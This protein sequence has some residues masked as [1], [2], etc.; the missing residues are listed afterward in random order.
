MLKALLIELYNSWFT[1]KTVKLVFLASKGIQESYFL[2]FE[3]RW[4][5]WKLALGQNF[6]KIIS[7][8]SRSVAMFLRIQTKICWRF[9]FNICLRA[10][11]Y[12]VR[13]SKTKANKTTKQQI[14]SHL[15]RVDFSRFLVVSKAAMQELNCV[16]QWQV[17]FCGSVFAN[18]DRFILFEMNT[19]S[20]KLPLK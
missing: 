19:E 3:L 11:W 7:D 5:L 20:W 10:V 15:K 18:P 13:S 16:A 2:L 8:K 4:A 6:I 17:K 14:H 12:R 1:E 9:I